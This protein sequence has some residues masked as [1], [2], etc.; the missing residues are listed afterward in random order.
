MK[1]DKP[2]EMRIYELLGIKTFRKMA[3]VFRDFIW[4]IFL[5]K[6]SK[7]ERKKFLYHNAS[8]II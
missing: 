4:N 5:L 8:N 1:K 2:T 3:F 7:E 6:M